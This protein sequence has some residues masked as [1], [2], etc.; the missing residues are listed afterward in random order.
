MRAKDSA[1]SLSSDDLRNAREALGNAPASEN[2]SLIA[3]NELTAI[4][5]SYCYPGIKIWL[6]GE[7]FY[8]PGKFSY[9]PSKD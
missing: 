4:I 9:E 3:P 7:V 1:S 2:L 8:E 6:N 5:W